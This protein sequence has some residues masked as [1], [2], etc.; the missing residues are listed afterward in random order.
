M[1][2]SL[3]GMLQVLWPLELI[4]A[5]NASLATASAALQA[6]KPIEALVYNIPAGP[7]DL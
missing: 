4:V 5:S 6:R 7:E 1:S 2:H 3:A